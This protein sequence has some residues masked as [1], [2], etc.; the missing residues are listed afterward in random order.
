MLKETIGRLRFDLEEMRS[1]ANNVA[2]T[3]LE[4]LGTVSKSLG[5]ELA[6]RLVQDPEPDAAV[7]TAGI[8]GDEGEG[9]EDIVITTHRRIVSRAHL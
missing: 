4:S 5:R 2:G 7:D 1:A 3:G 6:R 9:D 8:E